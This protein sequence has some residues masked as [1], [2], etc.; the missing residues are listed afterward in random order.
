MAKLRIAYV[1]NNVSFFVSHR[2]PLALAAIS[3]GYEIILITGQASSAITENIANKK[4]AKTE[5]KHKRTAFRSSGTNPIVE[6]FGLL[7]LIFYLA[8][9][10]PNIVHCASPKGILYGGIA[11]RICLSEGLIL[12]ISG[13]GYINTKS[14]KQVLARRFFRSIYMILSRFV[15]KHRNM[16]VIV[17]NKDDYA[18]ILNL[19]LARE[20]QFVFIPGSGV[21]LSLF[22]NCSINSKKKIVLL[23]ARMI[24][25]KGIEE[26]VTAAKEI[27]QIEPAWRFI[28]AGA[29]DYDSP[30]S[31]P[32]SCLILWQSNGVVEWLGHVDDMAPLFEQAAIVCLPSYYGEGMPKALLEAAAAS[33]AIVTTDIA[34]CRDAIEVD[35][36]GD[37]VSPRDSDALAATILALIKDN[38]RRKA[39]GTN[40]RMRAISLF[41]IN[42]V[43]DT[44]LAIYDK[45]SSKPSYY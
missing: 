45:L 40:G 38:T 3:K 2:M 22:E 33:C 5:I 28:L 17:Q 16:R 24:R 30:T 4:L 29:A 7:Q 35:I 1:V 9:F 32:E 20:S 18:L 26:F 21:D 12:A 25:D 36:T 42:S 31:I 19:G 44:T 8:K 15:F 6:I 34:G 27:K 37:L 11:A 23:P 13:M 10:R 41:S 43:I 39:Y 14:T